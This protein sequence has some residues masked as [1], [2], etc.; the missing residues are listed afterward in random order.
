MPNGKAA[1]LDGVYAEIWKTD[2]F[3]NILLDLFIGTG[4]LL[5]GE[6]PQERSLSGII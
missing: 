4:T 5:R 3:N 6:K 1:G 2:R